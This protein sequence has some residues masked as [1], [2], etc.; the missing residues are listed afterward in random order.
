MVDYCAYRV[1]RFEIP[2]N[3]EPWVQIQDLDGNIR[4]VTFAVHRN[5]DTNELSLDVVRHFTGLDS[6]PY[7]PDSSPWDEAER[8]IESD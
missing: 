3:G 4:E 6:R 5:L 1:V 8:P 2:R 7:F